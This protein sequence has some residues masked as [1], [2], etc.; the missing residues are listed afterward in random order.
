MKKFLAILCAAVMTVGLG[1]GITACNKSE[2]SNYKVYAPDGA[3]A[4]ALA[5]LCAEEN[6]GYDISVVNSSTITN[7]VTGE[8]PKADFAIVP[9]NAAVKMLGNGQNYKMLGTVTHGNLFLLKKESGEEITSSNLSSLAGK[10]VGVINLANVPGLMLKV[11]LQQNSVPFNQLTD[12][13]EIATDKVNLKNISDEEAKTAINPTN[14][15][16]DYFVVPEPAATTKINATQG[17]LSV[18]AS[19]Q[20]LYGGEGGY[21]QAVAVAKTSVIENDEKAV[22]SFIKALKDNQTWINDAATSAETIV[23]AIQSKMSGDLAPT[24]TAANLNSTVIANCGI[25]FTS[26]SDGKQSVLDIISKLN[27]V[28]N[29]AW[30]TP[31]DEFF[32]GV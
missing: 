23:T 29:N 24:F 27:A 9:V 21:P 16:C 10:T 20:T 28:S 14:S 32:Y 31:A 25:R 11:I 18:A 17:K 19:L 8:N 4:L 22:E 7:Y 13:A 1:L 30:G 6:S 3:P 5:Q 26:N 15:E 2:A 12:G